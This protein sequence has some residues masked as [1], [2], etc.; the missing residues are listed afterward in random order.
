MLTQLQIDEKVLK[1]QKVIWHTM[2]PLEIFIRSVTLRQVKY[3]LRT[4]GEEGTN[5]EFIPIDF[6]T[7]G[8]YPYIGMHVVVDFRVYGEAWSCPRLTTKLLGDENFNIASYLG[9]KVTQRMRHLIL[10]K[11]D[12]LTK[13]K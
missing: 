5:H 3:D 2:D 13:V 8:T 11:Y 4:D 9:T 1:I 7:V 12:T 10:A 6:K